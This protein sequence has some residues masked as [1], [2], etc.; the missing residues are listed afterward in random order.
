MKSHRL[1]LSNMNLQFP[2]LKIFSA[3]FIKT[4]ILALILGG[5]YALG[6]APIYFWPATL[7]SIAGIYW[8]IR[9]TQQQV[10]AIS[11]GYGLGFFGVGTS[12]IYVSIHQFGH[13]PVPL[14]LILTLIFCLY[15]SVYPLLMVWGYKRYFQ[16]IS[17]NQSLLVFSFL[18]LA[19]DALRGWV[20]SGF[21]WL[22]AGYSFT[23]TWLIGW[24]PLVGVHGVTVLAVASA[25]SIIHLIVE[26]QKLVPIL[27]M[28]FAWVG[29]LLLT[30]INWSEKIADPV[31][32]TLVQPNIDQS[33]KWSPEH[34]WNTLD[35]LKQQTQKAAAGIVIWPEAAVPTFEKRLR[36]NL[37]KIALEAKLKGQTIVTGIPLSNQDNSQAYNGVMVLDDRDQEKQYYYKRRLVPFGEYVP[38][39]D[40]L[41]GLIEFFDL[42]MSAFSLGAEDQQPLKVGDAKLGLAICYEITYPALV[43]QQARQSNIILT[44]SN[45]AWF[46]HSWGPYQH[47]QMA[48]FRSAEAAMPLVRSTNNGIT[49]VT[50]A[51]GITQA[52]LPQFV[53]DN[54]ETEVQPM[55]SHSPVLYYRPLW[56]L[57]LLLGIPT[58]LL[59]WRTKGIALVLKR[60]KQVQKPVID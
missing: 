14:A 26:R 48:R 20:F 23:D 9:N 25:V 60:L 38:L 34:L 45:D 46:G 57:L 43:H 22:Y 58:A 50:N 24:A 54:L 59:Y 15:L 28:G 4:F 7:L 55:K 31:K 18:W 3:D 30:P 32:I 53:L 13:A 51:K 10:L 47:Y 11:L 12:W 35:L 42:P 56:V 29:G 40:I 6:F 49:A 2:D 8:L 17:T 5:I 21:P 41:R 52:Q 37:E 44:L 39:Q 16:K 19:T 27:I 1:N 33:I 36:P